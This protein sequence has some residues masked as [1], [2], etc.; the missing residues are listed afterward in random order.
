MIVW[1]DKQPIYIQLA[2]R[3]SGQLLD[4]QLREGAPMPSVRNLASDYLLNPLTVSRSLKVLQDA[5]LL[6]NR[7]GQGLYVEVGARSQLLQRSRKRFI[8]EEWPLILERLRLLQ[9]RPDQL[10]WEE[11]V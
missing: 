5:G 10:S 7:R 3:L 6:Q 11:D 2:D 4:G 8:E 1:D 9:I